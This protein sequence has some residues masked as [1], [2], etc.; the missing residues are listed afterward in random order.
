MTGL[1]EARETI[2]SSVSTLGPEVVPLPDA[3]GRVLAFDHL[4]SWDLPM[5]DNSAMDGYAVR[6]ADCWEGSVLP[7]RGFLP[8]G[9]PAV[10]ALEPGQ[11][12]RIL[13]GA[14]LPAGADAVVPFELTDTVPDGVRLLARPAVGDHVRKQGGDLRAGEAVVPAGRT[15]GPAEIA[16]LA[17]TGV[18]T[19]PVIR[20]PRVAVLSTG[21]ELLMPGEALQDG[22]IYDSNSPALAAAALRAGAVPTVLPIARDHPD[23]LRRRLEE[24]LQGDVLVTSAGVSAGDRD[25]VREVLG[26]LGV[27]EAFWSVA[28]QPGRPMAFAATDTCRVFSLPGNPVAALLTFEVFVRP[29]LRRMLGHGSPVEPTLRVRLGEDVRPRSDRVTLRRVRLDRTPDGPVAMSAGRQATG[30]LATLARADG[31]AFVPSGEDIL[32]AGTQ[33]DVQPLRTES[34]FTGGA[35]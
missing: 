9:K 34:D 32:P 1:E 13:T 31:I 12:A 27:K 4:S 19:V 15:L 8:A 20:R 2:L 33:V 30:F 22:R 3:V 24:G 29:A 26:D 7:V 21:D 6:A 14:P 17:A 11:A 25:L 23:D 28:V 18:S 35:A 10:D 5:W 16:L